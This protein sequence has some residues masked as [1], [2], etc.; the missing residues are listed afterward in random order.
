MKLPK[1]VLIFDPRRDNNP[2]SRP[3][4]YPRSPVRIAAGRKTPSTIESEALRASVLSPGVNV[5][6]EDELKYIL[7]FQ[8]S[9]ERL[10]RGAF[11]VIVA[12]AKDEELVG[13][14]SDFSINDARDII[15][16]TFDVNAL[17]DMKADS[18]DQIRA[19]SRERL[20]QLK[21][22]MPGIRNPASAYA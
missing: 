4:R 20:N 3:V 13:E 12:A 21:D 9:E 14:I 11:R 2:G 7:G 10:R 5:L 16:N 19:W 22:Q 8:G 15:F 18:R 17:E 1:K 6:S